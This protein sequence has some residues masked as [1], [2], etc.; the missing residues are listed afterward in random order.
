MASLRDIR[1]RIKSVKSTRQITKAVKMVAAAK[2]RRAQDAIVSARPYAGTLDKMISEVM[3]RAENGAVSHPL[4]EQRPVKKIEVLVMTSDRGLAGGFNSNINRRVLKFLNENAGKYAEVSIT[5]VGRKGGDFFRSR[6]FKIRKEYP[7]LMNKVSYAAAV[8]VA[9][10]L[11]GRFLK[12]EIDAVFL[13]NNEFISAIAQRINFTQLLPFEAASSKSEVAKADYLYEPSSQ[14]VLDKLVPQALNIKI[15][16]ALLDSVA[17]E[18]GARMTAM[19]NATKNAGEMIGK[20]T[21][22]YNRTRQAAI[23]KEL[24]EIVSGAEALK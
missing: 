18:H 13:A 12:G 3:S 8:E 14:S 4:L 16:R 10:E 1:K 15:F 5:S 11:A 17:S 24:M 20:L 19:E 23:T 21:L 6:G 9:T 22:H 2:L 7:G